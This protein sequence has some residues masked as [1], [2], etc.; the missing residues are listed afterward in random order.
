MKTLILFIL[1]AASG[2]AVIP[3]RAPS[4]V[5]KERLD[6]ERCKWQYWGEKA[7][8]RKE[9]TSASFSLERGNTMMVEVNVT[10]RVSIH[11]ARVLRRECRSDIEAGAVVKAEYKTVR[12][13]WRP[14]SDGLFPVD[15]ELNGHSRWV[16]LERAGEDG[17]WAVYRGRA[18]FFVYA[19]KKKITD[20]PPPG[21][22]RTLTLRVNGREAGRLYLHD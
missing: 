18:V 1:I 6:R 8:G 16:V 22:A 7:L 19:G 17:R 14:L 11:I 15:I 10:H 12:K 9:S 3:G 13:R 2:C 20:K 5:D 21:P 4:I